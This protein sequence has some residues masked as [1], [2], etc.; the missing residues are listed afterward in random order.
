MRNVPRLSKYTFILPISSEKY[1]VYNALLES[2]CVIDFELKKILD[3]LENPNKQQKALKHLS[4]SGYLDDLKELGI[5]TFFEEDFEETMYTYWL[6]RL[7]YDYFHGAFLILP[8]YDCNMDCIYC[9]EEPLEGSIKKPEY[10]NMDIANTFLKWVKKLFYKR[11][12]K[13]I[14]ITYY[15]G[16]PLLNFKIIEYL[17]QELIKDAKENNREYEFRILTN[18]TLLT[19]SIAKILY[20]NCDITSIHVTLDGPKEIHDKRRPFRGG[21]GTFDIIYQNLKSWV[22][23]FPDVII[24]INVDK[25]NWTYVPSLLDILKND[26]LQNKVRIYYGRI[27]ERKRCPRHGFQIFDEQWD[28]IVL[29]LYKETTARGFKLQWHPFKTLCTAYY[30][31]HFII[32]PVGRILKCWDLL[33]DEGEQYAIGDL[34]KILRKENFEPE[35]VFT[36]W[37]Y[38]WMSHNPLM[39]SKCRQCK[40]LPVCNGECPANTLDKTGCL[41]AEPVCSGFVPGFEE[42]LKLYVMEKYKDSVEKF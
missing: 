35:D 30:D 39:F 19:P 33:G 5:I 4:E 34:R 23:I 31:N 15:G 14:G 36:E 22:D 28:K 37:L 26:G 2:L 25:E 8:T 12:T 7:R 11:N 18:G 17:S 13:K 32:D 27:Y 6:N 29:K 1:I 16:E 42:L 41:F 21:K 9:Y 24:R 10:M 38:K 3:E 20:E 40:F